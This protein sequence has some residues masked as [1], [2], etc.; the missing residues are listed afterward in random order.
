MYSM[1]E[2]LLTQGLLDSTSCKWRIITISDI[3]KLGSD[4]PVTAGETVNN[5]KKT[6]WEEKP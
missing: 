4:T 1:N 5:N 6:A 2:I 3:A